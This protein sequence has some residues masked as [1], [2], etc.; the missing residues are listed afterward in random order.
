[1]E[2]LLPSREETDKL[3]LFYISNVEQVHRII[4]IPTFRREYTNYWAPRPPRQPAMTALILAMMS[5]ACGAMT[6]SAGASSHSGYPRIIIRWIGACEGWLRQQSSRHRKLVHYQIACLIYLAKRINI[7]RKKLYWKETGSLIQDAISDGLHLEP[8]PSVNSPYIREMKRRIWATLRELDMQNCVE[9]GLPTLLHSIETTIS[10]P[11]NIDD[12][13]FD[14]TTQQLPNS[15]DGGTYTDTSYQHHSSLTW[16]VRLDISRR[17]YS[18]GCSKTLTYDE[19]LQYTHQLT[20]ALHSVP[21]WDDTREQ[22]S[23]QNTQFASTFLKLQLIELILAMHRPY[24]QRQGEKF[25]LSENVCYQMARDI[26]LLTSNLS[27]SDCQRLT[28]L[29]EDLL[30]GLL[31]L[32]RI[33]LLQPKGSCHSISVG[34]E[35]TQWFESQNSRADMTQTQLAW[36]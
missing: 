14:E 1:M 27:S 17:L 24:L 8:S 21:A 36:Q 35:F 2:A 4:H 5:I 18:P 28:F 34:L 22:G 11:S 31:Y 26:V 15:V 19:V 9:F 16:N 12:E 33:S 32:A 30:V 6:A 20:Q 23:S 25:W 10:A 29:R 13:V 7:V 3:I